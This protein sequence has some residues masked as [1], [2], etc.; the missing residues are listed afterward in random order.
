MIEL[1]LYEADSQAAEFTAAA[2]A[3]EAGGLACLPTDT[4]YGIACLPSHAGAVEKLYQLKGRDRDK[5]LA[6]VFG[7]IAD[8]LRLLPEMHPAVRSAVER[9]LPGPL[10]VIIDAAGDQSTALSAALGSPGTLGVR[11]LPQPLDNIYRQL[12]SPLA[13]TSANLSG[14]PE[15]GSLDEVS[16]TVL[17][18][19]DFAVDAGRCGLSVP[20]T[21][22]DLRPL[23]SGGSAIILR[24]GTMDV[25]EIQQI[26]AAAIRAKNDEN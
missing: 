4:V 13:L 11:V 25:R 1:K 21:V 23:A 12:P 9:L 6:A 8:L 2:A 10:T 17:E 5:P 16:P 20:S 24:E 19:C 3:L 22:V 7:E 14:Q 15:P 26:L 18:A